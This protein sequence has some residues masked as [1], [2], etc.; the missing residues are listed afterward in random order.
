VVTVGVAVVLAVTGAAP[1]LN[2]PR[3]KRFFEGELTGIELA[4]KPAACLGR[5]TTLTL[6]DVG[7]CQQTKKL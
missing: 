7:L 4:Y 5:E 6:S 1:R 2:L 3:I